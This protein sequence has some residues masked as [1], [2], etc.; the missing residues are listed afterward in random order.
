MTDE[1][2]QPTSGKL[3]ATE[4][5]ENLTKLKEE[6]DKTYPENHVNT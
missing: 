2:T 1:R 3:D 4:N 6:P 5:L